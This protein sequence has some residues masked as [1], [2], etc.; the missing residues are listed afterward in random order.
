MTTP[1]LRE[2]L[3]VAMDFESISEAR[4]LW[5][6]LRGYVF[7]VKVSLDIVLA[8]D[9]ADFVEE[10]RE[11]DCRIIADL[12][13]LQKP[14]AV[15]E[16]LIGIECLAL[17]A[18]SVY[19]DREIIAIAR[20]Y[21]STSKLLTPILHTTLPQALLDRLSKPD[22]LGKLVA[23]RAM[24]AVKWGVDGVITSGLEL[25]DIG[26]EFG[27]SILCLVPGIRDSE[28][29]V[30]FPDDQKRTVTVESALSSGAT[31]LIVGRPITRSGNARA[32]VIK[33]QARISQAC[34]LSDYGI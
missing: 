14:S 33:F 11:F 15:K 16:I 30:N 21:C 10:L 28:I 23:H 26:T 5:Q 12:K 2:R 1:N 6:V 22:G 20:A 8:A 19:F 4:D 9:F 31:Y 27:H 17:D 25:N 3:V 32:E 29:E 24:E 13:A 18:V 34:C 7:S